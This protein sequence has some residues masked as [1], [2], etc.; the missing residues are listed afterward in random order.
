VRLLCV[1]L[2]SSEKGTFFGG[3][4]RLHIQGRKVSQAKTKKQAASFFWFSGFLLG[5]PEEGGN[6]FLL[7]FASFPEYTTLQHRKP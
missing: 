7:K 6:I 2:S 5:L 1:I 4:Y 3:T